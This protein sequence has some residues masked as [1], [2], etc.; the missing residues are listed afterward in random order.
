MWRPV[1]LTLVVLLV[2]SDRAD[3]GAPVAWQTKSLELVERVWKPQCETLT[4]AFAQ[5]PA[6]IVE[7]DMV[8]NVS[9]WATPGTCTIFLN[10]STEWLGYPHM[11]TVVL[12]EGGHLV[13]REHSDRGIM[14]PVGFVGRGRGTVNGRRVIMWDGVDRRCLRPMDKR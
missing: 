4:I 11:C 12:H 7:A 5:P 8:A 13:G 3:A 9:G 1:L 14:Q 6:G 10:E 2:S